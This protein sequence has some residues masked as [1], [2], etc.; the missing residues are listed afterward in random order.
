MFLKSVLSFYFIFFT[1]TD[2]IDSRKWNDKLCSGFGID[3]GVHGGIDISA[4]AETFISR[5]ERHVSFIFLEHPN[6]FTQ[7]MMFN[8]EVSGKDFK[9]AV[10]VFE[11]LCHVAVPDLS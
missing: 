8:Y 6:R 1:F 10:Q 2:N 11:D 3:K 7:K 5:Q 9:K 4:S